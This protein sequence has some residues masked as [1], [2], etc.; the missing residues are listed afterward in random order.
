MIYESQYW[1]ED[2]LH[3]VRRLK[4]NSRKPCRDEPTLIKTEKDVFIGFYIMRKLAEAQK[5]T[6]A[7][8][9]L[10]VNILSYPRLSKPVDRINRDGWEELY[11]LETARAEK[12]K[13]SFV[14]NQII[15]SFIFCPVFDDETDRLLSVFFTSDRKR[16]TCIYCLDIQ[17]LIR[18][19]TAFGSDLI[20]SL[21]LERDPKT[22]EIS[23]KEAR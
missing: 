16:N 17:E 1:K 2:L 12:V 10:E 19:F 5:I 21:R 18:V 20:T 3:I 4:I 7:T 9:H 8:A 22:K 14:Y 6:D 13:I 11:D 23:I 15:H